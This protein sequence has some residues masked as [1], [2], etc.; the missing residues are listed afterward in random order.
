MPP[1]P[2]DIE[3]EASACTNELYYRDGPT[4][5]DIRRLDAPLVTETV[6]RYMREASEAMTKERDA[7]LVKLSALQGHIILAIGAIKMQQELYARNHDT[8][9][10]YEATSLTLTVLEKLKARIA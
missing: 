6:E 10:Q 9:P 8:L 7:A 1:P 3:H 4:A 5:K 2:Y